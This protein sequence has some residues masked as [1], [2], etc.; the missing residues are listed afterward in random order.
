LKFTPRYELIFALDAETA[1][2]LTASTSRR[3]AASTS[4]ESI[5]DR[6]YESSD[7]TVREKT[8]FARRRQYRVRRIHRAWDVSLESLSWERDMCSLRQTIVPS[9]DLA[10]LNS[11][12]IN[13]SWAGK[14]FHKKL[15]K[16]SL[17]P[18]LE[19]HF[20]RTLWKCESLDGEIRL[21]VDRNLQA[22][23]IQDQCP[24]TA[25]QTTSN[26]PVPVASSIVRMEFSVS[27]PSTFKALI[28]EFALL[29]EQP[30]VLLDLAKAQIIG[31]Q[32]INKS[33]T[34]AAPAAL[35]SKQEVATCQVG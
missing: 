35:G 8:K 31:V 5:C 17:M 29:P 13:E 27:L 23:S 10:T 6:Y 19:T 24:L 26:S 2:A 16:H 7:I 14:W 4:S 15:V 11:A 22:N 3:M 34:L 21:T 28:Y 12:I 1:D 20:D 9:S 33:Q 18:S 32:A 30:T 25:T